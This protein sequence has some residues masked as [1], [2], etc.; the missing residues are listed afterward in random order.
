MWK[1]WSVIFSLTMVAGRGYYQSSAI[2]GMF[3]RDFLYLSESASSAIV[4]VLMAFGLLCGLFG[5]A[6]ADTFFG[7]FDIIWAGSVI[8]LLAILLLFTS[9]LMCSGIHTLY[10]VLSVTALFIMGMSGLMFPCI[11]AFVAPHTIGSI[12]PYKLVP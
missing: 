7:L 3:L 2:T 8:G 6:L 11:T 10:V 12:R 4:N 5:G 1:W 9:C